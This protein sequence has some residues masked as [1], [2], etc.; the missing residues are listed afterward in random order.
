MV[1]CAQHSSRG[2]QD[3][4]Q[5]LPLVSV[6]LFLINLLNIQCSQRNHLLSYIKERNARAI[7]DKPIRSSVNSRITPYQYALVYALDFTSELDQGW[8]IRQ[9]FFMPRPQA[10]TYKFAQ[11]FTRWYGIDMKVVLYNEIFHVTCLP[12]IQGKNNLLQQL[13]ST[14]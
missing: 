11:L 7:H 1:L 14:L 3:C 13:C 4:F 5:H 2:L 8:P 9:D 6:Y 10:R 12:S